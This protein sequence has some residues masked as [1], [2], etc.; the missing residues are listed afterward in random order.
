[1]PRIAI[2]VPDALFK[3]LQTEAEQRGF[4]SASAFVRHAIQTE[5]Q[6][7]ESVVAQ[8]EER[9]AGTMDRLAKEVRAL[10]TAQLA[11]F[12][13]VDSLVKMF[14]TCV[15]EPPNDA[16]APAKARAK[17]RYEK[18]LLSVAQGM[19]GESRGALKELSRVDS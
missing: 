15:P 17:R 7:G 2:R 16:L 8:V 12:A 3:Q 4:E 1:M 18:F 13:L 14:L 5:L 9:I 11:T 10:H 19:C 6:H